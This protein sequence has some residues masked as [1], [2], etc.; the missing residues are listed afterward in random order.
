MQNVLVWILMGGFSL[1]GALSA[2][3]GS[4]DVERQERE[5][6]FE[7][8]Q[9]R[10]LCEHQ[11]G[12]WSFRARQ[13]LLTER[14]WCEIEQGGYWDSQSQND[15]DNVGMCFANRDDAREYNCVVNGHRWVEEYRVCV[16]V[17]SREA[18]EERGWIWVPEQ[19]A[20]AIDEKDACQL[21]GH[22]WSDAHHVCLDS[23]AA[24]DCEARGGVWVPERNVCASDAREACRLR[25][26]VWFEDRQ[27]CAESL[28][29]I[30]CMSTG[31]IWLP[32]IHECIY[33]TPD[34][35]P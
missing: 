12:R 19:N 20:C 8:T 2:P 9:R 32:D 25:G 26:H 34:P 27:T 29:A 7:E 11:G 5:S 31:G 16:D 10:I 30:E 13:C 1:L 3:S 4:G 14:E 15:P 33:L 18:C 17:P 28:D 24:R 23:P 21:R 22:T 35:N 6:A